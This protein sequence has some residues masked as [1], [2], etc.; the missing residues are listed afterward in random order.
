MVIKDGSTLL[1]SN[2]ICVVQPEIGGIVGVTL[3][4]GVGVS[5]PGVDV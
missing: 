5:P 2:V 3:G 4:V 1:V